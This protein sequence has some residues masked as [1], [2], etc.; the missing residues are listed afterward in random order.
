MLIL[1]SLSYSQSI[2][3]LIPSDYSA[4]IF[5]TFWFYKDFTHGRIWDDHF[6]TIPA[7]LVQFCVKAFPTEG[8]SLYIEENGHGPG[9]LWTCNEC[10]FLLLECTFA[11]YV[12]SPSII[13]YHTVSF[14]N[15]MLFPLL[16]FATFFF[17]GLEGWGRREGKGKEEDG[18]L[19][20][21]HSKREGNKG[22]FSLF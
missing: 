5:R 3:C 21:S 13:L 19:I 16:L 1:L 20:V 7:F 12:N 2:L 4:A 8:S 11:G 14:C 10:C 17:A 22:Y 18:E 9:A 6:R 15:Y